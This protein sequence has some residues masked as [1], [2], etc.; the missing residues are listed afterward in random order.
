MLGKFQTAAFITAAIFWLFPSYGYCAGS[1]PTESDL[2]MLVSE[3]DRL[4]TIT[5]KLGQDV[6]RYHTHY[7]KRLE[8]ATEYTEPMAHAQN[9]MY[10]LRNLQKILYLVVAECEFEKAIMKI[11]IEN[12]KILNYNSRIGYIKS[13]LSESEKVIAGMPRELKDESNGS[14]VPLLNDIVLQVQNLNKS[15]PLQILE[16]F[17]DSNTESSLPLPSSF[18]QLGKSAEGFATVI[19]NYRMASEKALRKYESDMSNLPLAIWSSWKFQMALTKVYESDVWAS[20]CHLTKQYSTL[21]GFEKMN[22]NALK[23]LAENVQYLNT[24]KQDID[25]E[26]AKPNSFFPPQVSQDYT[27]AFDA[28][29][30]ALVEALASDGLV[31][32]EVASK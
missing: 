13:M 25:E 1:V 5:D 31:L 29:R 28:W 18:V 23:H 9:S 10:S 32:P 3:A 24:W 30:K 7:K 12:N 11:S 19:A 6:D 17:S 14:L 27:R 16:K 2:K 21:P 8:G 22:A 26:T 4:Y 15:W 20:A